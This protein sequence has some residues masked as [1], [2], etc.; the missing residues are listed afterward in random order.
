M[1]ITELKLWEN[2]KKWILPSEENERQLYSIEENL[3]L[4]DSS[5]GRIFKSNE[6]QLWKKI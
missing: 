6:L 3:S 2:E 1:K 4:L 5:C